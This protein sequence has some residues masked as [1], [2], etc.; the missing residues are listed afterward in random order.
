LKKPAV[1]L[2]VILAAGTASAVDPPAGLRFEISF[3]SSAREEPADGRVFVIVARKGNPEPRLQFGKDGGQYHST[4][5][6]GRD[7]EGLAP[8]QAVIVAG[9]ALGY[10]IARLADL[11][12]GEYFVQA[13]LNVY[14]T[15]HRA[16][17]HILKLHMDE[18]EGQDFQVSPGNLYSEVRK[19]RLDPARAEALRL[20]L[21]RRIPPIEMPRDTEF[22]K[23]VR[24]QSALASKFWGRPIFVGATVLLPRDYEKNKGVF[25]PVNYE[26]GHFDTGTPGGFGETI[27]VPPG[28]EERQRKR[29]REAEE[30]TK[31]WLSDRFPRML[32]VTFQHPTPYYDDSYAVDSP[33]NGPYGQ[34]VMTELIP[35]IETHFRAIRQ[36]WARILSGGSTGGWE[37]LALQVFHPDDFGGTFSACPDPVDFHSFQIVNIYDWD[38]A[39]H[40]DLDFL[41]V[42][43]PGEQDTEGVVRSTMEQQ[44]KYERALGPHGRSGE[45]W[46]CW[47]AVYGPAG[48]DGYFQP[49]FDPETGAIDKKVAEYWR[50]HSDLT[51][52]LKRHWSEVGGRLAGK[53]HITA[54]EMDTYYLNN[55]VHRLDDFLKTTSNPAWGGSIFYGSREPHCWPGPLSR[56]ER[57]QQMA[58]Y[59]AER[60]PKDADRVW[61]RE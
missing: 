6:F 26:Q 55:A 56:T 48:A 7:V 39:W 40:R 34:I 9:D 57:F 35:Y 18:W 5:F 14:T 38:N 44:L 49:L 47:Q 22:V 15:F 31:A 32:Y 4:P 50:E 54:G 29:A 41:R 10:P 27:E 19:I 8:G 25:Y 42:P 37:A 2:A 51:A 1:F 16:D 60:A 43:L 36:P 28:A 3:P 24:F 12:A 33:N 52:Y 45:D 13:M 11:P 17:G 58:R 23:H 46:D 21:D 53:I 20:S 30:F 59:A 61:W